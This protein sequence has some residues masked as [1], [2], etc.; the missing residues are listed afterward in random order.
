MADS[1]PLSF[2]ALAKTAPNPAVGGYPYQLRGN[3]LD[4][5]F[6][7]ATEDFNT[8]DFKVTNALGAGGHKNRKIALNVQI[9]TGS[10]TGQI[11]VWNGLN[12]EPSVA[13]PTTGTHVL[14]SVDGALTWI[15]T[16]EC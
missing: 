1:P 6:V 9:K 10:A 12:W 7:F 8:D 2:E 3:D 4:K 15:S 11:A 14:G 5:N 13:P 16:E